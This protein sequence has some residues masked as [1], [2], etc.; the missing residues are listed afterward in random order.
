M[1][2]DHSRYISNNKFEAFYYREIDE[3]EVTETHSLHFSVVWPGTKCLN[4]KAA[5]EIDNVKTNKFNLEVILAER[6]VMSRFSHVPLL[7]VLP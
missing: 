4:S 6:I 5:Y 2:G 1:A 3:N 7:S